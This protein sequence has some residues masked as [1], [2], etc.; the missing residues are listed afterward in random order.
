M[1]DSENQQPVGSSQQVT[2]QGKKSKTRKTSNCRQSYRWEK[3]TGSWVEAQSIIAD[4]ELKQDAPPVADTPAV[5]SKSTKN[6]L[7]MTQWLS[8]ISIFVSLAT[9]TKRS[10]AF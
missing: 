7:T 2:P 8:I 5:E 6:V 3:L 4:K 10:K 9:N 1:A